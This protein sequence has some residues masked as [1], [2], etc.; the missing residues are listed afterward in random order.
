MSWVVTI[1]FIIATLVSSLTLYNAQTLS[2]AN[3]QGEASAISGNMLVYHRYVVA[4]AVA[5]PGV[6]GAVADGSLGLPAW[7]SRNTGVANY[8][9][10]G[11]GYTYYLSAPAG[12]AYQ[13]LGD[14]NNSIY[15]GINQGG[16]V[17]NPLSGASAIAV[18]VAIPDGAVVYGN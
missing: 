15:A 17:T 6:T 3:A 11:K 7:F 8:V 2:A 14:T 16:T 18:P 1:F 10:S 5:N 9:A 12:L 13:I 4:Y